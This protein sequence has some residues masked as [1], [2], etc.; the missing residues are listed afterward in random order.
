MGDEAQ[1]WS[2]NFKERGLKEGGRERDAREQRGL[3]GG[4]RERDAREQRG[5]KE[6]L[7]S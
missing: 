7:S 4:R 6:A 3:K 5:K 2:F 1:R